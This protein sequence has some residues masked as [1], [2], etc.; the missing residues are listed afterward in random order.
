MLKYFRNTVLGCLYLFSIT[1][2]SHGPGISR[3]DAF[4]AADI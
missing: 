3:R 4:R 1:G 2:Y